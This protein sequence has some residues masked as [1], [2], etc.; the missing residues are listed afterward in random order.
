M[1]QIISKER[2][3]GCDLCIKVCPTDVFDKE[4]DYP[5]IARQSDCQTCYMCELY[6]PANAMYVSPLPEE[7]Q[8]LQEDTLIESGLIGSYRETI[9]WGKGRKSAASLDR[10]HFLNELKTNDA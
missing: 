9:G 3:V 4:G 7:N 8:V 1:I 6:C 10:F 5:V 2:C